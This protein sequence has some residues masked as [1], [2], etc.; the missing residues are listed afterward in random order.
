MCQQ[1]YAHMK[2]DKFSAKNQLDFK[3]LVNT[4]SF[5]LYVA[6][7]WKMTLDNGLS[8]VALF[9]DFEQAFDTID[10]QTLELKLKAKGISGYC[11][12]LLDTIWLADVNM[13]IMMEQS[14][15]IAFLHSVSRKDLYLGHICFQYMLMM[16]QMYQKLEKFI[17]TQTI[18]L[19]S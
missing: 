17:Y 2:G 9:I 11:Y 6:E 19:N 7:T 1:R 14:P 4:V 13:S 5:P 8:I 16:C 18:Q 15:N 10:H 12:S 3:Q